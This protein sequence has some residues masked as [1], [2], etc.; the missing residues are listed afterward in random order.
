MQN[1]SQW[2]YSEWFLKRQKQTLNIWTIFQCNLQNW[3]SIQRMPREQGNQMFYFHQNKTITHFK[4]V[5]SRRHSKCSKTNI[6]GFV[7][8]VRYL[9]QNLKIIISSAKEITILIQS[10]NELQYYMSKQTHFPHS[11]LFYFPV[12]L[13]FFPNTENAPMKP[14]S[15]VYYRRK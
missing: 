8:Y 10:N 12:C 15:F 14:V 5:I 1:L 2:D 11:T 6:M 9:L 7:Q 4:S 3:Q 13:G